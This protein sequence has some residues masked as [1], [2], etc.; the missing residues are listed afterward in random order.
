MKR[1]YRGLLLFLL[2]SCSIQ[3]VSAAS[4]SVTLNGTPLSFDSAPYI[5]KGRVL[6]PMRGVLEA[7]G[8]S[9]YWQEHTRS[10]LAM[11]EN[12]RISLPLDST[13]VQVNQKAVQI[14][15][16]ATLKN[17]RTYVPLRFLAE[18]SG[19]DVKWDN[20]SSTVLLQYETK[21]KIEKED[22]IVYIQTNKI[23]GSGIVLSENGLICTNYHIIENASTAQFLF[24]N[25]Q[26]YQGETTVVGLDRQND[27]ALLKIDLSGLT[28]ARTSLQY[29]IGEKVT[30]IGSPNGQRNIST[31]GRITGFDRDVIAATAEISNGSSGGGLFN[32][33]GA[34]IGMTSFYSKEQY[35]SI[36]LSKILKVPQLISIPLQEMKHDTYNPAAPQ[37][38]RCSKDGIYANVSWSPVYGADYYHVYTAPD[39][40]GP[41]TLMENSKGE[42]KWYWGF[43]QCFSI[44]YEP[45][46]FYLKVS[47]VVGG[48]ETPLSQPIEIRR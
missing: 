10:V 20:T 17:D 22:S 3:T 43:P 32:S 25:G 29:D 41:Y 11:K 12:I 16:P 2:L 5:E 47:A 37:Q 23:Q 34:L 35:F 45:K 8:Y 40:N 44:T 1:F 21:K 13:T 7:L 28:P 36:P 9:V 31:T 15:V 33:D 48:V 19:A 27:I 6:V 14:D 39:K 24:H 26:V 42:E 4:V 46:P 38:L 30:A 18:Y